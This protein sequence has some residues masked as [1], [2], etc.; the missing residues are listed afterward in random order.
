[1]SVGDQCKRCGRIIQVGE[2]HINRP[3]SAVRAYFCTVKTTTGWFDDRGGTDWHY[4]PKA[5]TR[6]DYEDSTTPGQ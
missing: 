3:D 2:S 4:M 1:M 6:G 5:L